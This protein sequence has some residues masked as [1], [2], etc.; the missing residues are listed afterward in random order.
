MVAVVFIHEH[1]V[2]VTDRFGIAYRARVYGEERSDGSWK[3]WLEFVPEGTA[4]LQPGRRCRT[5]QETTQPDRAALEY[6][7]GGLEPIYL[8]GALARALRNTK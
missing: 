2:A 6:W 3:G 7:A 1:S 4:S 5:E 8:E